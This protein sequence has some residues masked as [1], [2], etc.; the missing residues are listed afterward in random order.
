MTCVKRK[1]SQAEQENKNLKQI[2]IYNMHK[3]YQYWYFYN[4]SILFN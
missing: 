3:V 1:Q 2:P 4:I